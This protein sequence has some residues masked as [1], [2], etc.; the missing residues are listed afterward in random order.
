MSWI[1]L[2]FPYWF[3]HPP[4]KFYFQTTSTVRCHTWSDLRPQPL[5]MWGIYSPGLLNGALLAS[6]VLAVLPSFFMQQI[7]SYLSA[8]FYFACVWQWK[9]EKIK[10]LVLVTQNRPSNTMQGR[11]HFSLK[12]VTSLFLQ[13][14]AYWTWAGYWGYDCEGEKPNWRIQIWK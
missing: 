1:R 9:G 6:S 7:C 12:K 14:G 8:L 4:S 11:N 2:I 5:W 13:P 10:V 3:D